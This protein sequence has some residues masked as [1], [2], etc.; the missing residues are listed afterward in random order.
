VPSGFSGEVC[1]L[2]AVILKANG[3]YNGPQ[4]KSVKQTTF[5]RRWSISRRYDADSLV[6]F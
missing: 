2:V 1:G 3:S 4:P 5:F 6:H